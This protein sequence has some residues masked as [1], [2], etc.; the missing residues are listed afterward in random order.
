M[1]SCKEFIRVFPRKILWWEYVVWVA[2]LYLKIE[3]SSI[4]FMVSTE[5][6]EWKD[7]QS[8]FKLFTILLYNNH[9]IEFCAGFIRF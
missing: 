4:M 9:K 1:R 6:Q 8:V 2:E 5:S 7:F 3:K